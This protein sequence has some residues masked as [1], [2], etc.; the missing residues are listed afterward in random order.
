MKSVVNVFKQNKLNG[1]LSIEKSLLLISSIE[2]ALAY[3]NDVL[4]FT[5]CESRL[6]A[7]S[8]ISQTISFHNAK[9]IAITKNPI[10]DARK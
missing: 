7:L 4:L 1:N 8:L 2:K 9:L 6:D 3:R 5:K 10:T